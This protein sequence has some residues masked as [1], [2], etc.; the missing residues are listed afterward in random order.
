MS[1]QSVS[2]VAPPTAV[3]MSP[4]YTIPSA[5]GGLAVYIRLCFYEASQRDPP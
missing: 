3:S 2:D 5:T 4:P 1:T